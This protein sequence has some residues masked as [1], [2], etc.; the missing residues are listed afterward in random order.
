MTFA[1][2]LCAAPTQTA[3]GN[4]VQR[5]A[6]ADT[7]PRLTAASCAEARDDAARGARDGGGVAR[8]ATA[9]AKPSADTPTTKHWDA[10]SMRRLLVVVKRDNPDVMYHVTN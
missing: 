4:G 9:D 5:H 1:R 8:G 6:P 7:S 2:S 10:C 3:H